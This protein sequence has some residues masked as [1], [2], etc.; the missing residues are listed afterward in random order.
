MR[1]AADYEKLTKI[2]DGCKTPQQLQT[3]FNY[4]VLFFQKANKSHLMTYDLQIKQK[5]EQLETTVHSLS[6]RF[7]A[8][9]RI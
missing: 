3:A 4:A 2:I 5:S 6:H 9:G 1:S 8:N 7:P